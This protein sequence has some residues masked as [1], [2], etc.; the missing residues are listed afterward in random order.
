L[1]K[2]QKESLKKMDRM[3][4]QFKQA[5]TVV[6]ATP[7][8]NFSLPAA[9]KAYF[10]SVM[11]K[12]ETW[13]IVGGNYSGLMKGK[14]AIIL[15]ASGGVYEGDMAAWEHGVSLA[16]IEFEFMGFEDIRCVHAAGMNA[17]EAVKE[18]NLAQAIESARAIAREWY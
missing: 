16:K 15:L 8:F 3:A 1:S 18:K 10:D 6:L 13:D 14:R 17:G 2:E 4:S 5:D 7:M 11:L 9:V 12:G